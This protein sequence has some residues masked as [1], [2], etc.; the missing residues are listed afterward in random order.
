MKVPTE[1]QE[2]KDVAI[3]LR[4]LRQYNQILCFTKSNQETFT[5]SWGTKARNKSEGLE[6]GLPDFIIV[7]K[8]CVLFV[9]LKKQKGVRGGASGSKLSPE[10]ELWIKSINGLQSKEVHATV[11]YG[12]S[13]AIDF[14]EK[15]L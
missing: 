13:E 3:Y 15:Y 11:A 14:I 10:Q 1:S 7:T 6:K 5:A 8:K 12:A 2:A 4:T 9:E